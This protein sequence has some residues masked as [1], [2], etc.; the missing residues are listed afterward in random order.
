LQR[1]FYHSSPVLGKDE[2]DDDK[3]AKDNNNDSNYIVINNTDMSEEELERMFEEEETKM[4]EEKEAKF[5]KNWKPGMR[6]RFLQQSIHL[7]EFKYELEPDK[8]EPRWTLRDKRC[9]ALAIKVGMMPV[10]DEWG[11]RHACTVLFMDNN[12]VL[13]HKTTEKHGYCAVQVAGGQRKRKNVGKAVMGQYKELLDDEENPPYLVREFLV[14][15]ESTLPPLH[16]QIHARHFVPGQNVDVAGT[17]KGKGFQ[18]AMKRHNFG[19]MPASHGVSKSHR[20][21]GSTGQCQ[22]PGRVFKGKK[23]AGHMGHERVTTQ[24]LRVVKVDRGRNLL[25]VI[26]SVPGNKGA[27]VEVRDAVKK[28]LW[29]TG[30]V[31]DGLDR[32]PLPTFA[33]DEAVDGCGASGHEVFMPLPDSDPLLPEDIAA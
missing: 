19:G 7:E 14:S 24:N 4:R 17:S 15:D 11:V 9:G 23:M 10:F 25:Y 8:H 12:V 28:P 18:G 31:L 5:V 33:C 16:S 2:D 3:A 13:G 6:K 1:Q 20:A 29:S 30:K 26:G 21:L 32:P 27:F 22:D